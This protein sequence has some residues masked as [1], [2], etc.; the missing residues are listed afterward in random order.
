MRGVLLFVFHRLSK[1]IVFSILIFVL[2]QG[3]I[4]HTTS[5]NNV[6]PEPRISFTFDDGFA[7]AYNLAAPILQSYNFPAVSYVDTANVGKPG[8]LSW[9]KV[10]KLQNNYGWEIG[11]HTST[12]PLMSQIPAS[13]QVKE[14]RDSKQTLTDHGLAV[15]AFA[16]PYGDYNNTVLAAAAREYGSHRGFH[17]IGDNPW[18]YNEHLIKVQQ[19][20]AGVSVKK[21]Q[22]YIDA[23]IKKKRWLVLV[24]HDIKK[25][26]SSDPE[27]HE[28]SSKGLEAIAAYAKKMNIQA[29]TV[30][31]TLIRSNVNLL[32]N[33]SF[34][35]GMERWSTDT[36]ELVTA[37]DAENGSLPEPGHA[38]KLVSGAE[39]AHLY[40][41]PITVSS[42]KTYMIKSF[43]HVADIVR[44]EVGYYIDEYGKDGHWISGQWKSSEKESFVENINF[45]Y[46]PTSS[47]VR[48]A[49]LQVYITP[50]PGTVAYVDNVQ[51]FPFK[52][53]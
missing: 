19:V 15:D 27:E 14:L 3:Q 34:N 25:N 12:H 48:Q 22:N 44:G 50:G 20:Q 28:Y 23:A 45:T 29:G 18:P 30:S 49:R 2:L 35:A 8:R 43:L 31:E 11:S 42:N 9:E 38:I 39:S 7:S 26:P 51:W 21:V 40:S 5:V 4:V 36:P 52:L 1:P 37:D 32:P 17:D 13:K 16:T 47:K 24:F 6:T 10:V 46:T 41:P 33:N 53:K